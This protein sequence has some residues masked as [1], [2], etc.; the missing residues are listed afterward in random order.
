MKTKNTF[1]TIIC[2]ILCHFINA[3]ETWQNPHIL[4]DEY[5]LYGIGDPYILKYNGTYYLYASTR[6]TETGVKV[7]SSRNITDWKYEGLCATDPVLKAAYA[8]ELIYWGGKFYMYT[9]PGGHGHY[10]FESNS[11]TGPFIRKTENIGHSIDGSVFKEDDGSLFFYHSGD[12]GIHAHRMYSPLSL[13]NTELILRE[14]RMGGWTEG[15][16]VIKRNGTYYMIYTGNHVLNP[17]YRIDLAVSKKNPAE[18][19]VPENDLNPVI[20]NTEGNFYGLGHGSLFM[21]PDLD[22]YYITYHNKAGDFGV[23]PY[24]QLDF[25]RIAFN[26]DKMAVLG[27]TNSPQVV[28]DK[29]SFAEYF[30]NSSFRNDWQLSVNADWQENQKGNFISYIPK[31]GHENERYSAIL[32]HNT[33]SDYTLEC[34]VRIPHESQFAIM[35]A[36]FN[37]SDESNYG[38]ALLHTQS[39]ELEVRFIKNGIWEDPLMI[40]VPGVNNY[41]SFHCIRIEKQGTGFRFF[42][43][44]MFKHVCTR[45]LPYGRT[46]VIS[47]GSAAQYG[48]FAWSSKV[49]GS[50]IF[51]AYKPIPG[52]ISA[53]HYNTETGNN[54][55]N[56]TYRKGPFEIESSPAGGFHIRAKKGDLFQYNTM[57]TAATAYSFSVKY[58]SAKNSKIRLRQAGKDISGSIALPSTGRNDKWSSF[59]VSNLKLEPGVSRIEIETEEGSFSFYSFTITPYQ[60]VTELKDNFDTG[61]FNSLWNYSNGTWSVHQ[62]HATVQG[63]GKR[64][65]GTTGMTDYKVKVNIRYDENMNGGL[66]FRVQNPANGGTGND[67]NAGT[68]FYRGY[69]FTLNPTGC[70]LGKQNYNWKEL[71]S[72]SGNYQRNRWYTVVAEMS[73]NTIRIYVDDMQVPVLEYTDNDNPFICGKAGLRSHFST[74]SFDNFEIRETDFTQLIYLQA[75]WNLFSVNVEP[76]DKKIETV[77]AGLEPDMVKDMESFW[78]A[79]QPEALNRLK[80][81]TP[82]NGY[83]VYMH[84]EGMLTIKGKPVEIPDYNF[85]KNGWN[86]VGASYPYFTPFENFFNEGNC[87]YIQTFDNLWIPGTSSL[88]SGFEAGK[89][90]FIEK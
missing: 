9:S 84:K 54:P 89:G 33:T 43:D 51:D 41:S 78:K 21:G 42:V 28:P 23:G 4:P 19:F 24:R 76:A 47:Y 59:T 56:S 8:P 58:A 31:P 14:T 66:I 85:L 57:V 86:L 63:C 32:K 70:T 67:S 73:G 44:G 35:G 34:N 83:L 11:P 1:T 65:M 26:G 81:I 50:G 13:D 61:H 88:T 62:Q 17:S 29:P 80:T 27:C 82:G 20:I 49:D 53:V 12:D 6:D 55:V 37:Y 3:Q 72:V 60:P 15:P 30:D 48:S 7:W 46:G 71:T 90:Y 64:T 38:I 10:I 16:F 40:P 68:D 74:I 52:T 45:D 69:F 36:I 5:P 77:F 79:G 18:G 75:G 2:I 25:D 22:S 87:K 39:N